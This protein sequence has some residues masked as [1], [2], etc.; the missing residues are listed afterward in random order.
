MAYFL[1]AYLVALVSF[2]P[3]GW[4][5]LEGVLLFFFGPMPLIPK[6]SPVSSYFAYITMYCL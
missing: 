4:G 3:A 1:S 6:F 2:V 5:V